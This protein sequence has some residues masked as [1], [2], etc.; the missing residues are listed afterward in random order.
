MSDGDKPVNK[1]IL[2]LQERFK[3]LTCLYQI[4]E[5]LIRPGSTI[6]EVFNSIIKVMPPGGNIL[7]CAGCEFFTN[8][9]IMLYLIL[10]KRHGF[11][12]QILYVRVNP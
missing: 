10:K 5:L 12:K 4:E 3:E 8:R 6:K 1:M 7:N 2:E 11:R 9:F